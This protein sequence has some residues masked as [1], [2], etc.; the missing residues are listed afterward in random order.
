M[1]VKIPSLSDAE[2]PITTE[3]QDSGV[4]KVSLEVN[5]CPCP[6]D[7]CAK[8]KDCECKECECNDTECCA[9]CKC[10]KKEGD[11]SCCQRWFPIF[12]RVN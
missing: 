2:P 3:P 12:S 4:I 10:E 9:S 6:K 7:E 11:A 8:G 5:C 1:D